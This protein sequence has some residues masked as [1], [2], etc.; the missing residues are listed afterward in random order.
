MFWYDSTYLLLIPAILIA[1][2]AQAK[3]STALSHW[4][5]IRAASG[6]SGAQVA[7][8]L[9]DQNQLYQVSVELT[10]SNMGDHY[11]PLQKVV[12]L[13]PEIY[14]GNSVA[15]LSV[16]AHET[17]HAIQHK[18]SYAFLS[19]RTLVFPLAYFGSNLAF[20]LFLFGFLFS[21]DLL[22]NIG[23]FMFAFAVL[24]QIVTLPVEYNASGRAKEM[25]LQYGL[26]TKEE[27]GGVKDV[28]DAA[29]L[30]YVAAAFMALMQFI[31]L[32][33]LRNRRR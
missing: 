14:S 1:A 12:R 4:K 6:L 33:A 29:A 24:F 27:A 23:I 13:S 7:R 31:R 17:G 20:P 28:L 19:F 21:F 10:Q 3:V 25:L 30:T 16:A 22:I 32:L 9:L 2:W 15:S 18:E 5:T 8:N 11:D 26:I